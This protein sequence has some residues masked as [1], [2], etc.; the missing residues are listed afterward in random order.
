MQVKS[1][2]AGSA[3][4]WII[5]EELGQVLIEVSARSAAAADSI[6]IPLLVKVST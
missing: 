2:D 3:S 6:S 5:T 1:M 4:F